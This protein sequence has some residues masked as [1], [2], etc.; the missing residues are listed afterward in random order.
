MN[1]WTVIS[2]F[3]VVIFSFLGGISM[4]YYTQTEPLQTELTDLKSEFRG[5][6][7]NFDCPSLL[8]IA[9]QTQSDFVMTMFLDNCVEYG[10]I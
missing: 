6:F 5:I 10:T 8:Y 1:D 2:I 9:K 7:Q 3:C 4:T